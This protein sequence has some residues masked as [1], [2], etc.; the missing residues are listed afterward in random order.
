METTQAAPTQYEVS[1][2]LTLGWIQIT[3]MGEE[4][5]YYVLADG[6]CGFV[7]ID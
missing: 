5:L 1:D 7:K 2:L 3:E 6:S 4:N